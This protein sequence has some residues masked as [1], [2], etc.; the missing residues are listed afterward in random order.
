MKPNPTLKWTDGVVELNP[1]TPIDRNFLLVID[2]RHP[3]KNRTF[4]F[5]DPLINTGFYKLGM[6]GR[7]GLKCFQ[8]LDNGLVKLLLA[9]IRLFYLVDD[10]LDD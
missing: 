5:H 4:R 8:N 3:E 7:G 2:P 10:I 1:E 9:W 6:P